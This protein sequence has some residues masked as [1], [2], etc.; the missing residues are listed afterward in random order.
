MH[1][2]LLSKSNKPKLNMWKNLLIKADLEP[3]ESVS[4]TMLLWD[5]DTLIA[6][7]SRDGNLLKCIAV[8][9]AHQG[10]GL[11]ATIITALKKEAFSEGAD[12]L[13][14]YTKP[15]NKT[16][17]SDLFFY[18]VAQTD[19]VLLMED[20]KDGINKFLDQFPADNDAGKIG[21]IVMN[22]NPFTLGHQYLIEC[23]CKDCDL[24]YVFVVSEDKSRFS[25]NDRIEMVRR[26]TAHIPNVKILPT[27]PYLISSATFPTY[28]LKDKE[29]VTQI[30]CLLD[31]EIF[32][33]YY[34]PKFNITTRYVGTE[35]TSPT[36]NQYNLSLKKLLPTHGIALKEIPRLEILGAPVSA[37]RVRGL[38][39][40]QNVQAMKSLVPD[41][42]YDF[43]VNKDL[44]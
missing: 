24:L 29:N 39:D 12:H 28:F 5:N 35:P 37:S 9:E 19:K 20:K 10:E 25:A 17:F 41:T 42:T 11:T 8:D 33:K 15:Q 21:C 18:P 4:T 1:I 22:C 32:I 3:D 7:G 36:T 44:I 6:T 16:M 23:A 2:E 14:L 40:S 34:A 43:L 27:G 30:Q 38:I 31:I 26:G 13:F